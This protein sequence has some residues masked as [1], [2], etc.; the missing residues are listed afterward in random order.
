MHDT[1]QQRVLREARAKAGDD[2][3]LAR[4]LSVEVAELAQWLSGDLPI[5]PTAFFA[6]LDILVGRVN[7]P[8]AAEPDHLSATF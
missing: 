8:Y 4:P 2:R 3:R 5:P 1:A 7:G 6:S